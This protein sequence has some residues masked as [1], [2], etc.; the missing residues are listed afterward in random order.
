MYTASPSSLLTTPE[1]NGARRVLRLGITAL[2][3]LLLFAACVAARAQHGTIGTTPRSAASR[4]GDDDPHQ[5]PGRQEMIKKLEIKRREEAYKENIE[6]AKESAAL[7]AELCQAFE[8][9]KRF[10]PAEQKKLG[11]MEKLA[12]SIRERAGG[13]DDKERLK[14]VPPGIEASFDQLRKLS[15]E[16]QVK[17]EKTPRHVISTS[18]IDT[19]NQLL[20]VIRHIRAFFK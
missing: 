15:E 20:D 14:E 7:G 3:A 5:I 13:D 4:G 8:H 18:V 1:Q 11:R 2:A 10:G 12:R 19:A 6:R 16:L 9:S 17:V